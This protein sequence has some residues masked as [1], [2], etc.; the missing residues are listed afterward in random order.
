MRAAS[1]SRAR[2]AAQHA[3][4]WSQP[5]S[6]LAAALREQLEAYHD[7][8]RRL[9]GRAP[10]APAAAPAVPDGRACRDFHAECAT[11]AAQVRRPGRAPHLASYDT[12]L[13]AHVASGALTQCGPLP[14]ARHELDPVLRL[15]SL[16]RLIAAQPNSLCGAHVKAGCLKLAEPLCAAHGRPARAGAHCSARA[17]CTSCGAGRVR[18]RSKA[19]PA[20]RARPRRAGARAG[21]VRGQ[22]ALHGGRRGP[23]GPLGLLPPGVRRVRAGRA[24]RRAAAGPCAFAGGGGADS[25]LPRPW[26]ALSQ[27]AWRCLHV[28]S[29]FVVCIESQPTHKSLRTRLS[30]LHGR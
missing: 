24:R 25:P 28:V 3:A 18:A 15:K 22:P 11:W 10:A 20:G 2:R 23:G 16:D 29:R 27:W 26:S 30:S 9:G 1:N 7:E 13:A 12:G 19:V 4:P 5:E 6:A 17:A 21:R 14:A 8:W